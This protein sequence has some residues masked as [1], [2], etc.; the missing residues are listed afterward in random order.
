MRKTLVVCS[1]I[2]VATLA[3]AGCST[4]QKEQPKKRIAGIVFQE[5]QFF[6]LILFGMRDAATRNDVELLEANSAGKPDKEVGLI[7]TYIANNVDAI[8]ISPLSARAS[9]AALTR[10]HEK[11]VTI[12]TYNTPVEGDLAV[13]FIESDQVDLGAST[14]RA[15]RAYI[16]QT[17]KGKAKIAIISG[18]S[19]IPEQAMMRINGFKE[20]VLKLPGVSIVSEQDAW[21]AEQ[22]TKKVGDILTANPD[23]DIVWAA[24]EGGTVGAVMAV[25]NAGKAGKVAVFGTDISEQL[26][27]FLL[28]DDG[29]LQA[30]TGQRPFEIRSMAVDAAVK[31]LKG[32][33]VEKKAS[34]PGVL[35]TREKPDEIRTFRQRLKELSR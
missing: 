34:L 7:N 31:A 4:K 8:V 9:V 16:E 5:D 26:S 23:V 22:A 32:Q 28:D 35:L 27:N 21:L 11:G 14:R 17:L 18:K 20:E 33:T 25:K 2:V 19:Q 1:F 12:V 24:N 3:T 30:I 15:A 6:R 10:A 29:V 13:S